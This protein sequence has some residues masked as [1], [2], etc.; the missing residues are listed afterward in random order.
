MIEVAQLLQPH[1]L[2]HE[3]HIIERIEAASAKDVCLN[4]PVTRST[5]RVPSWWITR[6]M[7]PFLAL[8]GRTRSAMSAD[9]GRAEVR[10]ALSKRRD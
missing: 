4:G 3:P 7:S 5:F 2:F 10:G 1:D 8:F 9:R 6:R